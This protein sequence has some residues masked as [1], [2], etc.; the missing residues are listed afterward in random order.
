MT[1][2]TKGLNI[3]QRIHKAIPK[4]KTVAKNLKVTISSNNSYKAVSELDILNEVRPVEEE[5]GIVSY[6]IERTILET[7]ELVTT[8]KEGYE[9]SQLFMR[10]ETRYRFVNIDDPTDFIETI[11]WGDGIDSGDK[12]PGKAMTYSDKY[13]LMKV[14]KIMTGEDPD[15]QGSEDLNKAEPPK[16]PKATSKQV[17]MLT[18][19][20]KDENLEKLLKAQGVTALEEMSMKKASDLIKV[21]IEKAKAKEANK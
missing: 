6:P 20:Y 2:E 12:A 13:A 3:Y 5:F 11:T 4:I 19:Y 15:G 1:Q 10:I 8:T 14:Y 17:A 16:E 9:R 18:Q 21:L 7:R